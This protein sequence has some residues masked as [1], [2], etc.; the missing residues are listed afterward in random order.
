[1]TNCPA[2]CTVCMSLDEHLGLAEPCGR[3][4]FDNGCTRRIVE[5]TG[6]FGEEQILRKPCLHMG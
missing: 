1:M 2:H 3:G 4:Y 6:S 5:Q